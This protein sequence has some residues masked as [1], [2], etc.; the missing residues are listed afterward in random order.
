[1]QRVI[2]A[3]ARIPGCISQALNGGGTHIV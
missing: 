1:V 3:D 2:L